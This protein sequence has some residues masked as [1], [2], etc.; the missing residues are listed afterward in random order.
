M[1]SVGGIQTQVHR[2][3]Q[4][5]FHQQLPTHASLQTN[6]S[7]I[8]LPKKQPVQAVD[9]PGH[10]RIRVQYRDHFSDA[11]AIVFVVDASTVSRN[12]TAV[13]EYVSFPCSTFYFSM[14]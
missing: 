3:V 7:L 8:T 2:V 14:D 11:K 4:L 6:S 9:V 5:A 10:P 12:G 13:A 1:Y